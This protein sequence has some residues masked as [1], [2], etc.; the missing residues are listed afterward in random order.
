MILYEHAIIVFDE[1]QWSAFPGPNI[2]HL[3]CRAT[4]VDEHEQNVALL[5]TLLNGDW[6]STFPI[7]PCARVILLDCKVSVDHAAYLSIRLRHDLPSLQH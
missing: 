1:V 6:F 7:K 4:L 2:E 3:A 5:R